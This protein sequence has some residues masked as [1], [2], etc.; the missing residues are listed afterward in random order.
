[1][2]RTELSGVASEARRHGLVSS[3]LGYDEHIMSAIARGGAGMELFAEE[4]DTAVA[5]IA[6]EVEG[7]LAHTAQA[8]SVLIRPSERV[9][10]VRVL[11]DLSVTGPDGGLFAE[12]GSFYADEQRRLL[13]VFDVPA[14]AALGL[15]QIA[16]LEFSYVE[17]P[18]LKQH[19]ITVPPHINVVPGD[20]AAGRIPDPAVRS[21]VLYQQVQQAKRRASTHLSAGDT[22]SALAEIRDAQA[23]VHAALA[24]GPPSPLAADLVEEGHALD[25]L[26]AQTERGLTARAARYSSMERPTSRVNVAASRHVGS[27]R[28]MPKACSTSAVR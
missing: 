17:S 7:L 11:N 3:I 24:A 26:A 16:T 20:Q 1:M 22:T 5:L 15:T 13:L 23:V 4:P 27:R 2:T 19:T 8:A 18:A 28:Q 10:A 9:R 25:Y 6:G 14:L 12:L 21:E